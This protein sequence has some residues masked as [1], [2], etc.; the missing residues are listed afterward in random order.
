MKFHASHIAKFVLVAAISMSAIGIV[1]AQEDNSSSSNTE[2]NTSTT[3][4]TTP[5]NTEPTNTNTNTTPNN[6]PTNTNTN[7]TPNNE[8]TT[9]SNPLPTPSNNG[10]V[11]QQPFPFLTEQSVMC[12]LE[13]EVVPAAPA[14]VVNY[15]ENISF[16]DSDLGVALFKSEDANGQQ[17]MDLFNVQDGTTNGKYMFS[18]T[19][20]DIA[21]YMTEHPAKNTLLASGEGV[22]VYVLTTGEIQVNA[23]P[24]AEGKYHV[25]IF[26]GIPWTHVYGYTIDPVK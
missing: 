8:P 1:G 16:N 22:A 17:Q 10:C 9:P 20:Q 2:S 18:V 7:T 12:E 5:T 11:V 15:E 4:T 21:P 24:D 13:I 23:G 3:T 6:E 26:N 14:P 19:Q 25:K